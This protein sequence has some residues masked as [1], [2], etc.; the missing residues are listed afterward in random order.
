MFDAL[1]AEFTMLEI[2]KE[3]SCQLCGSNP[4]IDALKDYN[5]QCKSR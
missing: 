4:T 1:N 3:D 5:F 2:Y